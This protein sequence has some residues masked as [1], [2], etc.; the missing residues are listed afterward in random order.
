MKIV[1][2]LSFILFSI[3]AIAEKPVWIDDISKGCKKKELCA[4][5]VGESANG[6]KREARASLAKIFTTKIKSVFKQELSSQNGKISEE[7]S[8]SIVEATDA[9]LDGIEIK[10]NYEDKLYFYS[11][12]VINKKKAA[13]GFKSEIKKIDEKMTVLY[14]DRSARAANQLEEI[15]IKREVLNKRYHFLTGKNIASPVSYEEIYSNKKE[16]IGD[17]V[18][19]IYLDEVEPKLLEGKLLESLSKMGY[20][21][22]SGRKRN[23]DSTHILT[24]IVTAEKQYMKIEGFVKYKFIVKLKSANIRRVESGNL[25]L[26]DIQTGRNKQQAYEKALPALMEQLSKNISKLNFE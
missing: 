9:A 10:K 6:A 5:G 7:T 18:V 21:T 2:L 8:D 19:H 1:I 17:V 25:L 20:Q 12:A 4:V 23:K 11:L 26:E 14:E 15:Y 22:T 13:K 3:G 16:L 24:G